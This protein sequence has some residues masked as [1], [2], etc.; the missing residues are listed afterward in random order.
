ME[1]LNTQF[2]HGVDLLRQGK[3]DEALA[4]LQSVLESL[5]H[6]PAL[7]TNLGLAAAQSKKWGLSLS[8]LREAQEKGSNHP[9]TAQ[10]IEFVSS[11]LKVKEIP[12]QVE[13]WELFRSYVL[14]GLSL[15]ALLALGAVLVL[16]VGL[17]ALRFINE[18]KK[19]LLDEEPL[20]RI[21]IIHIFAGVLLSICTVLSLAKLVDL[22]DVRAVILPETVAAR[23]AAD[24]EAPA[25]FDL[26]G[27]L[28]IIVQ[29]EV[30]KE[31][32]TWAQ[33]RYPGGP[34]GWIEKKDLRI[35]Q[36]GFY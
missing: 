32:G 11:Q 15:P 26:F 21:R 1:Q 24:P 16:L 23:S 13:A 31:T 3:A 4:S 36:S 7:L 22:S 27:G 14:Q 33:V 8:Y 35:F 10:A 20:P 29:R 30:A 19:A 12:H 9:Q 25:L 28:E 17:L 34:V 6:D 5:P 18:R 2:A